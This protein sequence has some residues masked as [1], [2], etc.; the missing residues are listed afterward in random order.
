MESFNRVEKTLGFSNIEKILNNKGINRGNTY[1]GIK[2]L[3]IDLK[4]K[5]NVKKAF[6]N[7]KSPEEAIKVARNLG[8]KIN[9]EEIEN[10]E[11]LVES[12]LESVAGGRSKVTVESTSFNSNT[13]AAG[14]DSEAETSVT[15][16]AGE[17]G[18]S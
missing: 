6:L 3:Q 8:Y 9:E 7:I 13:T 4:E 18:K 16:V 2:E 17:R 11:D 12:M 10:N 1:K 5:D 14:D 15:W